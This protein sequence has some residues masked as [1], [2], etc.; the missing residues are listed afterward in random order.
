MITQDCNCL[1]NIQSTFCHCDSHVQRPGWSHAKKPASGS[2]SSAD[3]MWVCSLAQLVWVPRKAYQAQK[4]I[5]Y[6]PNFAQHFCISE[7][8]GRP[9]LQGP[10]LWHAEVTGDV[11][12]RLLSACPL[13]CRKVF[14]WPFSAWF[15]LF[16]YMV[17]AT[18]IE[19]LRDKVQGAFIIPRNVLSLLWLLQGGSVTLIVVPLSSPCCE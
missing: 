7:R 10:Y 1:I 11:P 14:G 5:L 9:G 2:T 3:V 18:K 8:P 17:W 4:G 12:G 13:A 19:E 15:D 6:T 16:S